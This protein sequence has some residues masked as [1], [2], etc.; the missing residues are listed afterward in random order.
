[1][2]VP[3]LG[4]G[5]CAPVDGADRASVDAGGTL[6]AAASPDRTAAGHRHRAGRADAGTQS[7]SDTGVAGVE[8]RPAA[9]TGHEPAEERVDDT[10][11]EPGMRA[12]HIVTGPRTGSSGTSCEYGLRDCVHLVRSRCQLGSGD[13][14]GVYS[15]TFHQDVVVGHTH[16]EA[17]GEGQASTCQGLPHHPVR[18]TAGVPAGADGIDP[19]SAV[20]PDDEPIHEAEHQHGRPPR[21]NRKDQDKMLIW[22]Q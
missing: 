9:G 4:A 22:L 10:A 12:R 17:G 18:Q 19:L 16:G 20:V 1:M 3:S 5:E 6:D 13:L 2:T 21:M 15:E 11:L 7:A 14:V 8:L